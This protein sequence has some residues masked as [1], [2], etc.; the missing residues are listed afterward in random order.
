MSA[1]PPKADIQ[2]PPGVKAHPKIYHPHISN[3]ALYA[4]KAQQINSFMPER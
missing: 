3:L 1:L 4:S 2:F